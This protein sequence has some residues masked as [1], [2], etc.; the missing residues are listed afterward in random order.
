MYIHS[1]WK[2]THI[3]DI[4]YKSR[5]RKSIENLDVF[6]ISATDDAALSILRINEIMYQTFFVVISKELEDVNKRCAHQA[7]NGDSFTEAYKALSNA[8]S[9]QLMVRNL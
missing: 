4:F 1:L 9:Y 7:K 2:R 3:F 6:Y 8:L 5:N